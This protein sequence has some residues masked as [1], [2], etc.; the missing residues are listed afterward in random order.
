MNAKPIEDDLRARMQR[1]LERA[2]NIDNIALIWGGYLGA[3]LEWGLIS[4]DTYN[5]L[6]KELPNTGQRDLFNLFMDEYDET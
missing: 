1:Q 5:H 2:D 4:P 3:L 6:T